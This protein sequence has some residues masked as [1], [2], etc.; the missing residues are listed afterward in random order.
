MKQKTTQSFVPLKEIRDGTIIREDGIFCAIVLVSSL[1]FDLKSDL[2][3]EAIL[4]QFQSML[5]SLEVNIQILIQSRRL[6]IQKHLEYLE[7]L[8]NKQ[9]VELL[10]LQTKEYIKFITEFT[11]SNEIM[12]KQFFLIIGYSPVQIKS[13]TLS[14]KKSKTNEQQNFFEEA[15]TQ[16]QQ[17]VSFVQ[18][19]IR[20]LGLRA[21]RLDTEAV[22]ELLYQTFNPGDTAP[23]PKL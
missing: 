8:Y 10:R 6:N 23:V 7:N 3:R 16:L 9:E 15:Q 1:N 17:R 13:L 2:E 20:S 5:N 22:T 12:T 18:N 14:F 19:N 11:E 4:N 21:V